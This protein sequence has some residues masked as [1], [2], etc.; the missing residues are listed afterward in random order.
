MANFKENNISPCNSSNSSGSTYPAHTMDCQQRQ[1]LAIEGLARTESIIQLA[2]KNQVSRKFIYNQMKKA[3]GALEKQFNQPSKDDKVLYWIPVTKE[4][5]DSVVMSLL[6]NCHSPY[7]GVISFFADNLDESIS[8]GKINN[9]AN[10]AVV[11][12]REVNDAE[13]LSNIREGSHDELFQGGMPV[14]A[15]IDLDSLYCYLLACEEQRDAETWA[16]HLW[17]K[18]EQ[19]LA[20]EL[21]IADAGKGLRAGQALAW[22]D[23]SCEGDHFH[24][25]HLLF[26][27][28]S[29]LD[30]QA[31]AAIENTNKLE[32][33]M[34]KAKK[35]CKGNTLSKKLA[36]AYK[37]EEKAVRLADDVRVLVNWVHNDILILNGTDA[38]IRKELYDIV[39]ELL[40][41]LI[42]L[43]EYRIKPV[44]RALSNQR[45]DLLAFAYRLDQQFNELSQEFQV[46]I[47]LVRQMLNLLHIS[48]ET[49]AYWYEASKLHKKFGSKFFYIQ[50]KVI[51]L[52]DH[53]H[54]TSS[55]VENFNSRLRT[56]FFLRRQIGSA[57]LDLLRFF[58]NHTS[59]MRSEHQERQGKSPAEMLNGQPHPHWL[60]ML[61]FKLFRK[62]KTAA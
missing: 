33:R 50:Q 14:L 17:D 34:E 35:K 2:E 47:E 40:G 12:A 54:R 24:A 29:T 51:H 43:C 27:L 38:D 44:W 31:Y 58:L 32:L 28:S 9:I 13:D 41:E 48:P 39:V 62:E 30:R 52:I 42:P 60:E 20:P 26:R 25:F 53:F 59:F 7:R 10:K 37:K 18:E 61:G 8:L 19:G 5:L 46:S 23:V 3:D 36:T 6:L 1:E 4:W 16:I 11:Q 49:Q 55:M 21:I 22:P 56:Y 57:F 15:G 45:D